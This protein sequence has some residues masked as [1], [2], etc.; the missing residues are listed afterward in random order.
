MTTK[1]ES[2][3]LPITDETRRA[4][5]CPDYDAATLVEDPS[6]FARQL[7]SDFGNSVQSSD[8]KAP[9]P[10]WWMTM[11]QVFVDHGPVVYTES[12]SVVIERFPS[13]S[14]ELIMPFV[15][16]RRFADQREY[17]FVISIL[18]LGDPKGL[19]RLIE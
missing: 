6:R 3:G 11:P 14:R 9:G 10:T 13:E 19:T 16:R 7:G 5:V 18:G 4:S 12:S 1:Y 17:R 15:K 2:V 8:V